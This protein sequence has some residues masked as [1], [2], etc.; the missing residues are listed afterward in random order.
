MKSLWIIFAL[1]IVAF[2]QNVKIG[3][4]T[5]SDSMAREYFL[6]CYARPDTI[7][8]QAFKEGDWFHEKLKH[9]IK[10]Y[11]PNLAKAR[12]TGGDSVYISFG[13]QLFLIAPREPSAADFRDWFLKRRKSK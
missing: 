1:P 9:K 10:W 12:T 6:D 8:S 4:I 5:I 13:G 7:P 3:D 11:S 2:A